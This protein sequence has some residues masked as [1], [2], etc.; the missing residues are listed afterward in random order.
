MFIF[1]A[2]AFLRNTEFHESIPATPFE[3]YHKRKVNTKIPSFPNDEFL[4]IDNFRLREVQHWTKAN[5]T[6]KQIAKRKREM[7]VLVVF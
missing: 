4:N 2:Y 6:S 1:R 3:I 5:R 7:H